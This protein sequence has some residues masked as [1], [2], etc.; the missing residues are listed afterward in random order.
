M[1]YLETQEG[2]P[3][4]SW[5]AV[6]TGVTIALVAYLF[7]SMLGAAIGAS[8]LNPLSRP[9]PARAFGFGSG[10]WMIVTTVVSVFVGGYF[11]GRCAPVLGW[12]HGL[13]AWALMVLFVVVALTSVIGSA[14][15]IAGNLANAGATTA[16]ASGSADGAAG[17]LSEEARNAIAS[18][19]GAASAPPSEGA[20]RQTADTAARAVARASWFSVAALFVGFVVA[21]GAGSLGFRHQPAFEKGEKTRLPQ[22]TV[23]SPVP[24]SPADRH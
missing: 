11:A 4:V 17:S 8:L 23:S 21:V 22:A 2:L 9:D 3:R 6:F 20:A 10:V 18:L 13:L 16:A 24:G 14:A 1:R 7:M 15:G 5:G 12:L 19:T